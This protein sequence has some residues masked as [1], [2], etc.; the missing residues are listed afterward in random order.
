MSQAAAA[1][2]FP[3]RKGGHC[4]S[5]ALRDLLEHHGL[6]YRGETLSEGAVFGLGGGLGFSYVE[7]PAIEPPIY[8]VGR[9]AGLERD[10]CA[11]LD[12]GLDL[13]R[14]DDPD[15]GWRTLRAELDAGRPTMI[16][17]D[18]K[19]LDYLRV[20]MH[21]TMHD[22]VVVGYDADEGIA[23]IADNDRE[24]IE[25][26]S[27][28][29]LAEAR[30]SNAFPAPNRHATWLMYWPAEL[31]SPIDAVTRGL[32]RAVANMRDGGAALTEQEPGDTDGAPDEEEPGEADAGAPDLGKGLAGIDLFAGRYVE[33]PERL[34]ERL[35]GA[36]RGLYMFI[37]K[38]GTGGAM[39]RSLHA[40]FLRDAA[41]WL[42]DVELAEIAET[43]ERLAHA[44][45]ELGS[46]ARGEDPVAAHARGVPLAAS[47]AELERSGV[48]AMERW[49]ASRRAITANR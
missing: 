8:L 24:E 7:L 47:I 25:R 15:E 45:S 16:W 37:V 10:L 49:L 40:G 36:L 46:V 35:E 44:W 27:L 5:S 12:I 34:G 6:G 20:R 42:E 1:E 26:C 4:G 13:R 2:T 9:T 19:H 28:A 33:W 43:Y 30:S 39:F 17:A 23:L 29:S 48:E 31:P 41:G 3:H 14:T 22:I 18:I 38:A 21:N 11:T 32:D